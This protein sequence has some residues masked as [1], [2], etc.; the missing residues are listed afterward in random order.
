[1]EVAILGAGLAGLSCAITLERH[2][3]R[4]VI[5]EK[6]DT[7][8]DRF[9]NAEAMFSILNR[10]YP[11]ALRLLAR[12][13][14]LLLTPVSEVRRLVIHSASRVGRIDGR[15]GWSNI[16]GRHPDAFECQLARQ[17]G[18][19]IETGSTLE[20]AQAAREFEKVVLATGDGE[21]AFRLGNYRCD[22]TCTLRGATARG[23]FRTD[24]PH[25]W[26]RCDI[27][28]KGFAWLV[29]Y[30]QQEAN[31]VFALPDYLENAALDLDAVW[32]RFLGQVRRDLGQDLPVS[33]PF[34]VRKYWMGRCRRPK[35]GGTYFVGN[36]LGA[37]SPGLGFGQFVSMLSGVFAAYD[38]CGL[39]PYEERARPLLENYEHSL[40]LRRAL[41]ELDDP[42]FDRLTG[43]LD[44]R[45]L[46]GL[47]GFLFRT[48]GRLDLLKW[49]SPLLRV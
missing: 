11:D 7:V 22:L 26:F 48:G 24:T 33:E 49:L 40:R 36:C 47:T 34:Q 6:R 1:M 41:E 16:R 15:I 37:P 46:A 3:V 4:P 8:G 31:L 10:P 5:L 30:S 32:E 39:E 42:A 14:H 44:V 23:H 35:I 2:G 27:L 21:Y 38:I 25:V 13:C 45:P 12:D 9:V 43:G 18:S 17:V 20:Y 29:P 28:P 19:R